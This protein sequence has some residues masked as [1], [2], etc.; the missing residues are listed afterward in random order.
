[1]A[2]SDPQLRKQIEEHLP[3]FVEWAERVEK[4]ALENG[5][6]LSPPLRAIAQALGIQN[7]NKIRVWEVDA[8]PTPENLEI[9]DL[10]EQSISGA[11][12]VPFGHAILVLRT[13]AN[14]YHLLTHELVHVRQFEQAGSLRS[15]LK[16]Y[17]EERM[18]FEYRDMPMEL[19]ATRE[20]DKH[21]PRHR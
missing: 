5:E 13:L 6:P 10:P 2:L 16:R 7:I 14:D 3:E 11:S 8:M 19:E 15:Y 12:G 21:F 1:M 17:S 18:R 20:A 4:E 9:E